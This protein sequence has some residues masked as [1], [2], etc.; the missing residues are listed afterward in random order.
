VQISK[1]ILQSL[2]F[3]IFLS[4]FGISFFIPRMYRQII[5]LEFII[6]APIVLITNYK[7]K[8]HSLSQ[9]Y[10]ALL[11]LFIAS[12]LLFGVPGSALG[13]VASA[14]AGLFVAQNDLVNLRKY[15]AFEI[16]F[17]ILTTLFF[18]IGSFNLIY[19]NYKNMFSIDLIASYFG[20]ASIN[21]ASLTISSFST[22]FAVWCIRKEMADSYFSLSQEIVLRILSLILAITVFVFFIIMETR[23]VLLSFLAPFL[24]A[25]HPK[26]LSHFISIILISSISLYL[27][28][29]GFYEYF[30][31]LM[32]PKGDSI[33]DIYAIE[34]SGQERSQ[35]AYTIFEK[36]IPSMSICIGCSEYLSFSGISN[37][38]ALSFPFSLFFVFEIFRF[39]I[40]YIIHF[41][42]LIKANTLFILVI[43][44]CFFSS[45]LQ[46]I[47]QS[48]FLS[49]VSL[50]Y[51]VGS[52]LVFAKICHKKETDKRT[53][54]L[55]DVRFQEVC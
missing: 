30:L 48:D 46:T 55:V 15:K 10:Q 45:L 8:R 53:T 6:L 20:I 54:N 3:L 25:V 52:G 29:P 9:T 17:L 18:I 34:L 43:I 47:F 26:K 51:A 49:I 41:R 14:S 1:K 42:S 39:I 36:A 2:S 21:Y 38:I 32:V 24:Y 37:L 16:N 44:T 12:T 35:S 50:F 28:F 22:I 4:S 13:Y 27:A 40:K 31:A 5:F 7:F 33:F 11:I 19:L 23:S